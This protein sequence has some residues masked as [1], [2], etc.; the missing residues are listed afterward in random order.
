MRR[1]LERLVVSAES[2]EDRAAVRMD[3]AALHGARAGGENDEIDA[4]RMVLAEAP[5]HEGA[6]ERLSAALA[7]A[8]RHAELADVLSEHLRRIRARG[9]RRPELALRL[10]RLAEER[11]RDG[12]RAMGIYE[13]LL[14]VDSSHVEALRAVARLATTRELWPRAVDA[15]SRLLEL[16]PGAAS[17]DIACLPARGGE[18]ADR[19]RRFGREGAPPRARP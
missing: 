18:P 3:L 6:F 16:V 9:E 19:G 7:R 10:A 5:D 17:V 15:L 12:P 13:E 4:L 14:A 8:E 11:L 1:L 2:D